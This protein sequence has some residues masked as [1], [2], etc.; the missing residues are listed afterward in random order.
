MRLE[1]G[2]LRAFHRKPDA[3]RTKSWRP[4]H[5]HD[6]LQKL[7]PGE[8]VPVELEVWLTSI[9]FEPADRLVLDVVSRDDPGIVPFLQYHPVDRLPKPEPGRRTNPVVFRQRRPL[10]LNWWVQ[11]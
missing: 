1:L 5:T 8:V 11:P 6:E 4:C 3:D 2:W 10:S 9:V 7:A